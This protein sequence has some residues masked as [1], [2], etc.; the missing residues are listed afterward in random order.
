MES[1]TSTFEDEP[2]GPLFLPRI[3]FHIDRG[4]AKGGGDTAATLITLG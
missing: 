4:K 1:E 2:T 3:N